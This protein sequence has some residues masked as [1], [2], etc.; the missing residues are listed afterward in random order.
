M[1]AAPPTILPETAGI[2]LDGVFRF[3]VRA[4]PGQRVAV[5][6]STDVKTWTEQQVLTATGVEIEVRDAG[7]T[8][9]E[10]YFRVKGH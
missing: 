8:A 9:A 4:A 6:A 5:L 10:R 3:R 1:A 7:E 2:G